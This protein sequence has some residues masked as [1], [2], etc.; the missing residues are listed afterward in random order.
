[1]GLSLL[2]RFLSVR[3]LSGAALDV[4]NE[5]QLPEDHPFWGYPKIVV[6]PHIAA[7][8]VPETAVDSGVSNIER[9]EKGEPPLYAVDFDRG[10]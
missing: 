3:Q 1:M 2:A 5:E 10:Y 6:T 8:S 4:F 9:I 7:F